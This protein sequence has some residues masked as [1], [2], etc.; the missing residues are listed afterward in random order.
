MSDDGGLSAL[1]S[2][3]MG[4]IG[5]LRKN[6]E[7]EISRLED[8]MNDLV[9]AVVSAI[10]EQTREVSEGLT[11]QTVAMVAGVAATTLELESTKIQIATDFEKTRVKLDLQTKAGLQIEIGK[12]LADLK[13]LR[14]KLRA[15]DKDIRARYEK[16]I[17]GKRHNQEL[18]NLNFGRI[19][20][21]YDHKVRTI[22][23][24]IF[25]LRELDFGHVEEATNT[26]A[27]DIHN[28]P[29]DVDLQRLKVRSETLDQSLAILRATRLDKI[30]HSV[31][32]LDR[33][34]REKH[35]I[36]P[37]QS[38]DSTAAVVGLA[39]L[40]PIGC[41]LHVASQLVTGTSTEPP[42]L[43]PSGKD[44]DLYA[45]AKAKERVKAMVERRA[46][47][48]ASAAQVKRLFDATQR[49]RGRGVITAES[50]SLLEDFLGRGQLRM[51]E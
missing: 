37:A 14:D 18:Y 3:L 6:V 4:E 39:V 16:A 24:H 1:R 50:E 51:V 47:L 19:F 26:S 40:S 45:S 34:V 23:E 31:S 30:L 12:K 48:V 25:E 28:L 7:S 13:G 10:R 21:E 43:K 17:E 15:F 2:E 46:G 5:G 29:M 11:K 20:D 27:E 38:S 32:S 35:G 36:P 49:L 42:R 44:F 8:V 9:E 41:E 33:L 22:G